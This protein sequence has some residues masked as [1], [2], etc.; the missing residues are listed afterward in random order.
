MQPL[1]VAEQV[2]QGVA[3]F[4]ATTFPATTPGF[5][6]VMTDFAQLR[7]VWLTRG[8]LLPAYRAEASTATTS[9]AAIH[10]SL[11]RSTPTMTRLSGAE[12]I[13]ASSALAVLSS[14]TPR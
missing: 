10:S 7:L 9:R 4:L 12:M 14:R 2:R 11:V 1:I 13:A 3:D 8:R 6:T 5:E